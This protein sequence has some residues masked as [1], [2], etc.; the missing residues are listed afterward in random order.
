MAWN[1]VIA[2][3]GFAGA[4]C[5]RELEEIVAAAIAAEP[6][7]VEQVK[8]G[9]Q[10]AIGRIMGGVMKETQGRADGGEVQKLIREKLGL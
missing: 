4:T 5:A 7:A 10:K 3:G 6:E 1:V 9:N 8:S 2:G